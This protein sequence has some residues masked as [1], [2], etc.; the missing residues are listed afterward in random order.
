MVR[1]SGPDPNSATRQDPR[2]ETKPPAGG[3]SART[4]RFPPSRGG[5]RPAF[6]LTADLAVALDN[7]LGSGQFL[8]PHRSTGMHLLGGNAHFGAEAELAAVGEASR[9]V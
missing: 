3:P 8:Q 5:S 1:G 9:R 4:G 2:R 6:W 7:P